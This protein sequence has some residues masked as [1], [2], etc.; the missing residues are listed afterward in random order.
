MPRGK[1]TEIVIGETV[2]DTRSAAIAYIQ[3]TLSQ[4]S[5]GEQI[6]GGDEAFMHNLIERHPRSVE[7]CGLGISHFTVERNPEFTNTRT[8]Y[9]HR[10]DGTG[11][12][13]S[14]YKCLDGESHDALLLKA[15]RSAVKDQIL[16]F[17]NGEFKRGPVQCPFLGTEL[18]WNN[19]H[20]DH[21]PPTTFQ[22]L[23]NAWIEAIGLAP[24]CI[25]VTESA[26][27]TFTRTVADPVLRESWRQFHDMHKRLRLTS[28]LGNLSHSKKQSKME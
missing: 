6:I 25:A 7:K 11:S 1:K 17:K 24:E 8:I 22:N 15:L 13:F 14:W 5:D 27:N 28:T 2:F 19:C 20:V 12:D 26:D 21:E 23:A 16:L 10:T 9:I 3:G 18:T 4:Y